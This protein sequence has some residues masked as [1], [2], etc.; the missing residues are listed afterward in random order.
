MSATLCPHGTIAIEFTA[1]ERRLIAHHAGNATLPV[2]RSKIFKGDARQ[3]AIREAQRPENQLVGLACEAAFYK[4]AEF[5]GS[6]GFDAFVANRQARDQNKFVGDNGIDCVLGG[7][8][9]TVDVKGSEPAE[10]WDFN[11]H[12]AM[13]LCLTHERDMPREKMANIAY[14]FAITEREANPECPAPVA[15]LLAGWLFGRELYG[16]TDRAYL[17]GWSAVGSS[18][19]K[20][21][22]LPS[23]V[24]VAQMATSA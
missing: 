20:M 10:G 1:E 23:Y 6:G 15:V 14:V 12:S 3:L 24:K 7:G 5:L 19:R 11:E 8:S 2:G 21:H 17:E 13:G 9:F 22:L 16:R 4:W 18:L